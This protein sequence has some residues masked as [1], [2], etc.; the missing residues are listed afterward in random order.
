MIEGEWREWSN[1]EGL[2][3]QN[4]YSLDEKQQLKLLLHICIFRLD[5]KALNLIQG[6][7]GNLPEANRKYNFL[8]GLAILAPPRVYALSLGTGGTVLFTK[9]CLGGIY[10]DMFSKTPFLGRGLLPQFLL[11]PAFSTN[12]PTPMQPKEFTNNWFRSF[13]LSFLKAKFVV[14]VRSVQY[15]K[16]RDKYEGTKPEKC[17]PGPAP[18]RP[19]LLWGTLGV[20]VITGC[21]VVYARN[22]RNTRNW[23]ADNAPWFD[24]FVS[25]AYQ[26]EYTYEE[27]AMKKFKQLKTFLNQFFFG[28]EGSIASDIET[29]RSQDLDKVP[30]RFAKSEYS[31]KPPPPPP[32]PAPPA[33]ECAPLVNI[34]KELV[35]LERDVHEATKHAVDHFTKATAFCTAYTKNLCRVV[36]ASVDSMDKN[37]FDALVTAQKERDTNEK[38]AKESAVKAR[39]AIDTLD[40]LIK[41]GEVKAN[42]ETLKKTQ[43][44]LKKFKE[45]ISVA[46][47][48]FEECMA[49]SSMADIYWNKVEAARDNYQKEL[50]ALF[51][52]ID[53]S[54]KHLELKGDTDLLLYHMSR[55]VQYLQQK[56]AEMQ[57]MAE[58]KLKKAID[59]HDEKDIIEAKVDIL[60]RKE[61][62]EKEKAYQQKSLEMLAEAH[63]QMKDQMKKQLEL[64]Q[65]MHD[66]RM[67]KLESDMKNNLDKAVA[68]RIEKE[69]AIFKDKMAQILGKMQAI[70]QTLRNRA[71]AEEEARRAM[72]LWAAA[73]ALLSTT[74]RITDRTSV[75]NEITALEKA[76]GKDNNLVMTILKSIPEEV[77]EM[78]V[79]TENALK[80]GFDRMEKTALKVALIGKEGAALPIYFLSW[81]QFKLL[82]TKLGAIPQDEL[83]D[84]PADFTK[85]DTFEIMQRARYFMEHGDLHSA[86]RYVN[87]L[88]GAPRAAS[89]N[90]R[91]A[92]KQH[93]ELRQAALAVMAQASASAQAR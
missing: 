82:F 28:K 29:M 10:E 43:C 16:Q 32:P 50:R 80:Q 12:P 92:V 41:D 51:P 36:E 57:V 4:S 78:G 68:E 63:R 67:K 56:I 21:A 54:A 46:E 37:T 66:A 75:R 61:N 5:Y 89:Q 22:S 42:A 38:T 34:T 26:E 27:Y 47:K 71:K 74:R 30:P 8:S 1:I 24:D 86:L 58:D 64:Q 59:C 83:D 73:E 6:R 55:Q 49:K 9:C 85:L 60:M 90:W 35:A 48:L 19:K 53:L 79:L 69:R 11:P 52:G 23:L 44:L 2:D 25:L 62:I 72:T 65:D 31:S 39:L 13:S 88:R 40:R 93:L 18:P 91:E 70:E 14:L 45:D 77:K 17:T 87:L 3:H 81:L 15:E 76:A 20:V 7:I 33:T 84:K